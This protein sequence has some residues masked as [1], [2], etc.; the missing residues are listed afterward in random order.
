MNRNLK[1]VLFFILLLASAALV[2]AAPEGHEAKIF[3]RIHSIKE[4][5]VAT[6]YPIEL[7]N[8]VLVEVLK[9]LK[10]DDEVL[11]QGVI[12]YHPVTKDDNTEMH[13]TFRVDD[14]RAVSLT[15]LGIKEPVMVESKREFRHEP[16]PGKNR[17]GV[18]GG[19]SEGLILTGSILLIKS[20]AQ[21]LADNVP[22]ELLNQQV[23]FSAAALA[24]GH[25]LWQELAKS[26]NLKF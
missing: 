23:L 17:F 4:A 19:F 16:R 24:T 14:I 3:L 21:G 10:A 13:P 25:M 1:N 18:S 9:N 15:R 7:E 26:L 8:Q 2:K 12:V 6:G 22:T 20:S 5:E 11:L